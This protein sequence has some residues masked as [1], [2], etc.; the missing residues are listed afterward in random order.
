MSNIKFDIAS[1]NGNFKLDYKTTSGKIY[2]LE[3]G[4]AFFSSKLVLVDS[5][6]T[7][8]ACRNGCKLYGRNGGCPP[9]S[10]NFSKMSRSHFLILYAKM[11]TKYYPPKV[12][13]GPYYTRWV[14]VETFMK[15]LTKRIGKNLAST[16]D[17]YFFSS[18]HCDSCK[19]KR[20]AVKD[21]KPCR[22]PDARTYSLEATGILVTELMKNVFDIELLWWRPKEPG[23]IPKYMVKVIGLSR[24][25]AFHAEETGKAIVSALNYDRILAHEYNVFAKSSS[26]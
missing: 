10:P 14:F 4:Y 11:L 9:F 6:A 12:L 7:I 22:K 1:Q 13:N 8:E 19:P 24:E 21:G 2:P 15:A 20:C 3:I 18:G 25:K 23:Y 16:L 17:G 26:L 5:I